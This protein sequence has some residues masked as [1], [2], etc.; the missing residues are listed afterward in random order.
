MRD[1][2]D[3]RPAIRQRTLQAIRA[4]HLD[5][6]DTTFPL[7][8]SK[9]VRMVTAEEDQAVLS[10]IIETLKLV[11]EVSQDLFIIQTWG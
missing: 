10:V 9:L 3:C 5:S 8:M 2:A 7:S 11:L 6:G 4:L 1:L